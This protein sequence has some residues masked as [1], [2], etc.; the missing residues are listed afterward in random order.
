MTFSCG[1]LPANLGCSFSP[2]SVTL[3]GNNNGS[4]T[5]IV[6]SVVTTAS[7]SSKGRYLWGAALAIAF[8]C[9]LVPFSGRKRRKALLGL[10]MILALTVA[11]VGCGGSGKPKVVAPTT[12]V[13]TITADG[14]SG[15]TAKTTPLVVTVNQR[16]KPAAYPTSAGFIALRVFSDC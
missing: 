8:G 15:A 2:T 5:V 11:G 4:V 6:S 1:I 10:C 9:F 3:D 14:G 13:T 7:S 16:T 12:T